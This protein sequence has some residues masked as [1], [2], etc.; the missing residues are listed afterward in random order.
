MLGSASLPKTRH[1]VRFG[2]TSFCY[3]A[4]RPFNPA[5]LMNFVS[6]YFVIVD[7]KEEDDGDDGD[8][9]PQI[10]DWIQIQQAEAK[11]KQGLRAK[12]LG[13]VLRSKGFIW[14]AHTHDLM[15]TLGSAGNTLTITSDGH[16]NCLDARV[17]DDDGDRE[18]QKKL[19]K[20]RVTS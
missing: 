1:E 3:K 16:W 7:S 9:E 17:Y 11:A 4:R 14:T 8:N 19:K 15:G 6:K 13:V 18:V 10:E 20:V 12:D 5:R 2:I